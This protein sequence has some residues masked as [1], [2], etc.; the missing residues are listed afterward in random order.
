MENM[1]VNGNLAIRAVGI[2]F[3][4]ITR[5][6]NLNK[7]TV[8]EKS[9]ENKRDKKV[10]T[11][12]INPLR[13]PD[14]S[15]YSAL[16]TNR[17][18]RSLLG[19][20]LYLS[21]SDNMNNEN[22]WTYLGQS[23]T[24]SFDDNSW[25]YASPGAYVYIV[26]A[27]YTNNVISIPAYSNI[28]EKDMNVLVNLNI[29]DINQAP[30]NTATVRLTN[31]DLDPTH[32]YEGISSNGIL[33]LQ[34]VRVGDYKIECFATGYNNFLAENVSVMTN[35]YS[36]EITMV[37]SDNVL[38]ESFENGTDFTASIAGWN[39]I[40]IDAQNTVGFDGVSFPGE[41]T[42]M[43]FIIFNPSA[44]N[45]AINMAVPH[46]TK[47]ASSFCANTGTTNDWLVSPQV[48]VGSNMRLTFNAR[49]FSPDYQLDRLKV[50]IAHYEDLSDLTFISAAPYIS[51]PAQ[52]T[53]YTFS[54]A[55]YSGSSI[56]V[57]F[58]NVSND[59]FMLMLDNVKVGLPSAGE[60]AV[61]PEITKLKNNYP[62]PFNPETNIAFDLAKGS[63]VE[64][65]I[66]NIK[67]QKVK[68]LLNEV[69]PAGSYTVNWKGKDDKGKSVASGIYFCR[70]KTRD[71]TSTRK[72][73]MLK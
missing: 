43:S 63:K 50:G 13:T 2:N 14:R 44:T 45:P 42:P 73:L 26:K 30:I 53:N 65:E 61:I 34:D 62:N 27:V 51:L 68:T 19:Y 64:I 3:G 16:N 72:M 69:K 66:Y 39:V 48:S 7:L 55:S 5:V 59:G 25:A 37:S 41:G 18:N 47:F 6:S 4:A 28:V 20:Q 17:I 9:L 32:I 10:N 15:N 12:V 35:P 11:I 46:G 71:Y 40:D 29:H 38:F 1:G 67:G 21:T 52:W 23:N 8:N 36:Y 60:P 33:A 49:S 56:Y 58:Q 57:A 22:L 24:T 31:N 70:F 54:L